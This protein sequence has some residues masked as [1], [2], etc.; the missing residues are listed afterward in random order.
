MDLTSSLSWSRGLCIILVLLV[1]W[2]L[3]LL[4]LIL[5]KLTENQRNLKHLAMLLSQKQEENRKEQSIDLGPK[6]SGADTLA[7][8]LKFKEQMSAELRQIKEMITNQY[9]AEGSDTPTQ[10]IGSP[11]TPS[12]ARDVWQ[13]FKAFLN[14]NYAKDSDEVFQLIQALQSQIDDLPT[15]RDTII[16]CCS[17]SDFM[18]LSDR[19]RQEFCEAATEAMSSAQIKLFSPKIGDKYDGVKLNIQKR[20]SDSD[21]VSK[22]TYF[23]V[24]RGSQ[25]IYKADVYVG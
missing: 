7:E 16:H 17:L 2:L 25:V 24:A 11:T 1:G 10:G 23:G 5:W 22:V 9:K 15:L 20:F 3:F 19:R 12:P 6:Q 8:M 13:K 21:R 14:I 18:E 4:N